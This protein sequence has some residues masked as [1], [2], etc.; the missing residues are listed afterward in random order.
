DLLLK[1][2]TF[3]A[4]TLKNNGVIMLCGSLA[5][6][7]GVLQALNTICETYNQKPLRYYQENKQLKMD[8]Y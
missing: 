6:Q 5:M 3:V 4:E 7:K 8:C 2:A 1:D